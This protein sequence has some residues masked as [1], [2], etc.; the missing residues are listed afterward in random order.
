MNYLYCYKMTWDTE[1]APNPHYGIL[2]LATCK[3]TIR[4]C[5]KVGDWI[6]GWTAVSVYDKNRHP[7]SFRDAQKLIYL[8]RI[9]NKI[10]YAEYWK[11]YPEKRPHE[12]SSGA[13]VSKRL[14]RPCQ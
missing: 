2:T 1:F 6:S 8:A 11:N 5:A 7:N 12:I 4:R 3:P 10:T 13:S 9:T 14:W